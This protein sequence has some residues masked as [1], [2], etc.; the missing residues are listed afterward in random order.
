MSSRPRKHARPFPELSFPVDDT[1]QLCVASLSSDGRRVKKRKINFIP[2]SPLGKSSSTK[3]QVDRFGDLQDFF[4][5]TG[6]VNQLEDLEE[7]EE[8]SARRSNAADNPLSEFKPKV[9]DY[10]KEL[11]CLE[12]RSSR[13]EACLCGRECMLKEHGSRPFHHVENWN[14]AFFERMTLKQL[15]LKIQLGHPRGEPCLI[16]R[17]SRSGFVVVDI[18]STQEVD[19]QF[20]MCQAPEYVGEQWQQLMRYELFPATT[21]QPHTAFTFR[22]LRF[23]HTLTLQGKVTVYDY[24]YAVHNRTDGAGLSHLKNRYEAF[25]RVV[26]LWRFLKILKRGGVGNKPGASLQNVNRGDLAARCLACPDPAVNLPKDWQLVAPDQRL[27]RRLISSEEQDPGLGTGYTYFVPQDDYHPFQK[28]S[29]DQKEV[30][31]CLSDLAA[32]AQANT[33]F[34]KGYATTGVVLCLCARHEVIEP[35]GAVD[36]DKGE[37]YALTDYAIS[38]SQTLSDNRLNRVLCYDIAC[39]YHRNF[40]RRIPN[41]PDSIR[42]PAHEDR[43]QFAV[44]KL[45]IRGHG[46]DCQQNFSLHLK[47]GMGQSDGEGSER[48]WGN[49]GPI[50][51]STWEMGPGHRR[52][53]IDDHFGGYS[54]RKR[55][56]LGDLLYKCLDEA[57]KQETLHAQEFAR[58]C[59]SQSKN[60][61]EW[62]K[63]VKDWENGV[64][65][66][67]PYE[68]PDLG[69]TEKDVRLAFAE[70]EAEQARMG[71]P[72]LHKISPSAFMEMIL[73][74]E[75]EQR[76]LLLD[77]RSNDYSTLLQQTEVIGRRARLQRAIGRLRNLQKIY[78]PLVLTTITLDHAG[79]DTPEPEL[80]NLLLPSSIEKDLRSRPEMQPWVEMELKFRKGQLRSSIHKIRSHLFIRRGMHQKRAM[81]VRGQK[82]ST[83]ARKQLAKNDSMLDEAKLK[84]RKAWQAS[85][86]LLDDDEDRIGYPYLT[87]DDV[88]QLEDPDLETKRNVRKMK[89]AQ[90]LETEQRLLVAGESRKT[91]SWIWD[92]FNAEGDSESILAAIRLEWMK[93][94]ARSLRWKEEVLLLKEEMRQTK[95]SLEYEATQWL[96][97]VTANETRSAEYEGITAYALRQAAVQRGLSAKFEAIWEKKQ[98]VATVQHPV[99]M[100]YE[101]DSSNDEED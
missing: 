71:L 90:F 7:Q 93:A 97:R 31:H 56:G 88:R 2:P 3:T 21:H 43:W 83:K 5:A 58:F 63:L 73:D 74:V 62:T 81:D 53:T 1:P 87:D 86:K 76:S 29:G 80:I 60:V 54:H 46:L 75:E 24:Y 44:P 19:V 47:K 85:K 39:Q 64:S 77:L 79:A 22:L 65:E 4:D 91:T 14:G 52:D 98:P 82:E 27:K 13:L 11:M 36:L 66:D 68:L 40:F 61:A 26:R 51:T 33:K 30:S 32:I 42:M 84:F 37:K 23:F 70:A 8:N 50:A 100:D 20:C 57:E 48:H 10:L 55:I 25:T 67:N 6:I 78:T 41:L 45:H 101:N 69:D 28:N 18:D 17:S 89:G 95:V 96:S 15:G 9:F 72:V 34:S 59:K 16:P 99:P 35:N 92:S 38:A 12:G 49:E 94:R